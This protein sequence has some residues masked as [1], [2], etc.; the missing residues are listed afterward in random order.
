MNINLI[1]LLSAGDELVEQ[2]N[3]HV[4]KAIK[5]NKISVL[6]SINAVKERGKAE[7]IIDCELSFSK[8]YWDNYI[9][10]KY[11]KGSIDNAIEG[12][13]IIKKHLQ[14]VDSKD[15]YEAVNSSYEKRANRKSGLPYD[16][17]RQ[18]FRGQ[19]ARLVNESKAVSTD[20]DKEILAARRSAL[21]VAE[22][23]YISRQ[24]KTLGVD[25]GKKKSRSM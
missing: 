15:A 11:M 20:V 13:S 22:K 14:I 1:R 6:D 2:R 19:I 25:L 24:A 5:D 23:D 17:A 16:E 10:D 4:E 8:H 21:F 9:N 12:L 7:D 18:S 3:S